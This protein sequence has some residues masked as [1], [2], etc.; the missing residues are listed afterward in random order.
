MKHAWKPV[1]LCGQYGKVWEKKS[2]TGVG[3]EPL[4]VSPPVRKSSNRVSG[5]PISTVHI[6]IFYIVSWMLLKA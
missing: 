2:E 6:N 3:A 4:T 5:S 1:E